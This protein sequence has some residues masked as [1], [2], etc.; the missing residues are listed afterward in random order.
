MEPSLLVQTFAKDEIT[1]FL[2]IQPFATVILQ[3]E[4]GDVLIV[5]PRAKYVLDPYPLAGAVLGKEFVTKNPDVAKRFKSATEKAIEFIRAN[6]TE[7]RKIFQ[8]YL[9]LE[10]NIAI[11]MPLARFE[12]VSEV[13]REAVGK[14]ADYEVEHKILDK[15]TDITNFFLEN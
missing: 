7:A 13:D 11:N 15:K 1:A 2:D 5:S 6:E 9:E 14:L 8:K 12:K 10:E 4:L 3:K